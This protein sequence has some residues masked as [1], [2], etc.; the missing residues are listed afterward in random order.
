MKNTAIT[1]QLDQGNASLS[2][3]PHFSRYSPHKDPLSSR[4]MNECKEPACPILEMTSQCTDKCV[5]VA[6]NDPTHP[7]PSCHIADGD[8]ICDS[9][10]VPDEDCGDCSGLEELLQCC[11][12]YHS[13]LSQPKS[14][15]PSLTQFNWN[16]QSTN[17]F[18]EQHVPRFSP[19]YS[20]IAPLGNASP[21]STQFTPVG[22][23]QH[24]PQFSPDMF[25]C[26]WGDCK[27][28]FPS[29]M[30]LVGHVNLDHLRPPSLTKESAPQQNQQFDTNTMS[31]HWGDCV[32]LPCTE[33]ISSS[34]TTV[35]TDTVLDALTTHLMQDHFGINYPFPQSMMARTALPP[36]IIPHD[37]TSTDV[38]PY[39]SPLDKSYPPDS[40]SPFTDAIKP[41]KW[42]GGKAHYECCWEGCSRNGTQGFSS[43]Q[44]VARHM[45][46]H[47]GH[48]PF[49]CKIC[50]A[51]FSETAT[52]QQHMRRHTQEKPYVCD[53]PG[54]GKAFAITGALTI[55]KRTHNGFKPFKCKFCEKAF[56]ESSNLS[57]HLRTH[58]GARPYPC[59]EGGCGKSFARPDQLARHMGVHRKKDPGLGME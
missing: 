11:T 9:A 14:L 37:E 15:D 24:L 55:H 20:T 48:R 13:Y 32:M 27:A 19:E 26:L 45:Q 1:H 5:V 31:C 42:S 43:K 23:P 34:S 38:P 53:F 7:E 12:D 36:E 4:S 30:E 39:P 40:P 44:K 16:P 33:S 25:T 54:C 46:S 2:L 52:L 50:N 59:P 10:C 56:A 6:C 3:T 41:C 35:F 58:T 29:L 51:H 21:E 22:L 8:M 49:K 57:K 18:V 17:G 47:T 28:T